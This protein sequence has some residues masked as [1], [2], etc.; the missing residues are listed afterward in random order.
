MQDPSLTQIREQI[1]NVILPL[2]LKGFQLKI[3]INKEII[4]DKSPI[5]EENGESILHKRKLK[6]IKTLMM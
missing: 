2:A 5:P 1:K 4:L 6:D 3:R